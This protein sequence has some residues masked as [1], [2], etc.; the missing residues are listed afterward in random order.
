M[1]EPSAALTRGWKLFLAFALVCGA[2]L[3][4]AWGLDIEYKGDERYM[5]EQTG[6]P[7]W[8]DR[9]PPVGMP[10]GVGIPNPGFSV[11]VFTALRAV[12]QSDTPPDLA[13]SVQLT[14]IVAIGV[15]LFVALR[16]VR[17][18]ERTAWLWAIAIVSVNPVAVLLQRKIWAQSILP[19]ACVALLACWLR[20]DR[21]F[22]AF[23]WGLI[24]ALIGQIHMSGFLFAA[25]LWL[26][27]LVFGAHLRDPRDP[28]W[29]AWG[30]GTAAGIVPL[31][32]WA[33]VMLSNEPGAPWSAIQQLLQPL[34]LLHFWWFWITDSLGLGLT[35]SLGNMEFGRFFRSP[36]L[37]G[38]PTFLIAL[39]HIQLATLAVVIGIRALRSHRVTS[40]SW[41]QVLAGNGSETSF[42]ILSAFWGYG[43]LLTLAG[44]GL[45]RHY[46]VITFPLEWIGL[47]FVT[48]TFKRDEDEVLGVIWVCQLLLSIAFLWYIHV[49][50]G[51]ATGDYGVA[52]GSQP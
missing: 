40:L 13:R 2:A 14:N 3:R 1:T 4:L 8:S 36:Y 52:Y 49:H 30:A 15:L 22:A 31:I 26:W 50:H 18:S 19:L 28:N 21:R 16:L 48:Q 34:S 37:N 29:K 12:S 39:V 7:L 33:R 51:A 45:Y 27:T 43:L 20:R 25:S 38:Y 17:H 9:L 11:W 10:S 23:G 46:L 24:G 47:A 6:R 41:K 42:L 44:I 35:S 32:P 5:F